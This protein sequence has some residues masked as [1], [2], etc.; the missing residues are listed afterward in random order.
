[1]TEELSRLGFSN[2]DTESTLNEVHYRLN[3]KVGS[4]CF[5]YSL[6]REQWIEGRVKS[7]S[8][9]VALNVEW[10]TVKYGNREKNVQR[11]SKSLK[12]KEL[13]VE[14]QC[15]NKLRGLVEKR[16][17]KKDVVDSTLKNEAGMLFC[18]TNVEKSTLSKM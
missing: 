10:L 8:V 1:M 3:W 9:D 12:P 11:F 4:E 14:Y 6:S 13:P 18:K 15:N 5:V 17:K 2:K 7:V 16:L